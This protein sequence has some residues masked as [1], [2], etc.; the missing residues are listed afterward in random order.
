MINLGLKPSP[1][2]LQIAYYHNLVETD[3][4]LAFAALRMDL[5]LMMKNLAKGF[6][7]ETSERESIGRL[8]RK[9]FDKGE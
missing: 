3:P 7:I 8:N 9:L 6:A 4:R 2:G 1:S 5:E